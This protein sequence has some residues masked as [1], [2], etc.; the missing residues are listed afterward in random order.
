MLCWT[1]MDRPGPDRTI[2]VLSSVR[3]SR[4]GPVLIGPVLVGLVRFTSKIFKSSWEIIGK[5]LCGAVKELFCNGKM[6]GEL[7]TTL[8]S[9]VPKCKIPTKS[10]FIEG[11]QICDNIMLAQE[12]M[13]GYTSK[14]KVARCA[15]KMI[16][17]R[18]P[19]ISIAFYFGDGVIEFNGYE[20]C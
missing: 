9:L 8:I 12:L 6:V 15:F 14:N 20:T 7:N 10:A 17:T 4:S 19:Y 3:Q 11:R 13:S 18:R 1:G 2:S 16:K 5:D